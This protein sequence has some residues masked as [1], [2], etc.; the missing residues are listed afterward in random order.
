MPLIICPILNVSQLELIRMDSESE[1]FDGVL[2]D[3][4]QKKMFDLEQGEE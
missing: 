2:K 1:E 3:R 4:R